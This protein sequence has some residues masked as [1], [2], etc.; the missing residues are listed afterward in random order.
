MT[1][2]GSTG[3]VH[4]HLPDILIVIRL[5]H[6]IQTVLSGFLRVV[7]V[8]AGHHEVLVIFGGSAGKVVLIHQ[9]ADSIVGEVA[10]TNVIDLFVVSEGEILNVGVYL[11]IGV[12]DT[13][14][15]TPLVKKLDKVVSGG[16]S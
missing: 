13:I 8:I 12:G 4:R 6:D 15:S 2:Y 10:L 14:G 11:V 7:G 16:H 1:H 3:D 9:P 5:S